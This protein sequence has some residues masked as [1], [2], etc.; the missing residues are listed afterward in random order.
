MFIVKTEDH[1]RRTVVVHQ[2]LGE[3]SVIPL[4]SESTERVA[5]KSRDLQSL[6]SVSG[7]PIITEGDP[8]RIETCDLKEVLGGSRNRPGP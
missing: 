3:S 5:K 6:L 1:S 4:S 7:H 2:K 8:K